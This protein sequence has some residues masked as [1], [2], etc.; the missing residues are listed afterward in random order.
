MLEAQ[1]TSYSRPQTPLSESKEDHYDM[2]DN[3]V[4]IHS[5]GTTADLTIVIVDVPPCNGLDRHGFSL[6]FLSNTFVL[7]KYYLSHRTRTDD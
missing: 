1:N 2:D 4:S 5:R 3:P 7:R 6:D